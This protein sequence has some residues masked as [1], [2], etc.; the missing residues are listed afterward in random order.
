MGELMRTA[1]LDLGASS[2]PAPRI[3]SPPSSLELRGLVKSFGA[4]QALRDVSLRFA[5]GKIHC[6]LGENGAGKSTVG[7]IV[8]GIHEADRGEI[9]LN[10]A[11]VQIRSV[12]E[13]RALGIA[14]VFQELSLA[15]DLTVAANICLGA[16]TRSGFGLLSRRADEAR[17]R[18]L[19]KELD[20]NVDVRARTGGLATANQQLVEI[21]K[22]LLIQP[23]I[24][25]LDEPTA[26]LGAA[27]K[28][29]LFAVLRRLR[30]AGT[31]LILITHHLDEVLEVGD[32]VSI[33]KDGQLV[34]SFAVDHSVAAGHIIEKIAGRAIG[35]GD[36]RRSASLG[37][38]VIRLEGLP[39]RRT[40]RVRR[41]EVVGLYGVVGCGREQIIQAISGLEPLGQGT[42]ILD[43]RP[44]RPRTPAHAA[45]QGV[46]YLPTG[47]ARNC[48]LPSRSIRENLTLT[49]LSRFRRWGLVQGRREREAAR[50][51]LASLHTRF[52]S[53]EDLITS[54]S[55][56]NQQKVMLGRSLGHGR[57][58]LVLEDPTAGIDVGAKQEIYGLMRAKA[59][60]GLAVLFVSSD[61]R[62]TIEVCDTIYTVYKGAIINMYEAPSFA[63]EPAIVA[64]VLGTAAVETAPTERSHVVH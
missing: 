57:R 43:G 48:I 50:K 5:P 24:L 46:A 6:L 9:L 11:P 25:I 7:K 47:R 61:L 49:Q 38:D 14:I 39:G 45:R 26:M 33:L 44:Y 36:I 31:T 13:A 52:A 4:T 53:P 42:M 34:D 56:G 28:R 37:E 2:A 15:P 63:D 27:E 23:R 30:D 64:D 35:A 18:A 22:A 16:E 3:S 54:L 29:R 60:E 32:W 59:D 20:F 41:G 8:G 40:V 55:G 51:Q 21:A 1:E 17:C 62:E 10:G 19:L 58:L 12:A